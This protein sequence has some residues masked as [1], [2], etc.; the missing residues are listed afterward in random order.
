[1]DNFVTGSK[2]QPSSQYKSTK[3]LS[4]DIPV[5][6]EYEPV[7]VK[8]FGDQ[9]VD[10]RNYIENKMVD[11]GLEFN[12]KLPLEFIEEVLDDDFFG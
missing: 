8:T 11:Y 2:T 5:A 10:L 4:I 7:F 6:W 9:K 12:D 1:M 3:G